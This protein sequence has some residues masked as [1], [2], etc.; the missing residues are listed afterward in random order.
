MG[1][2]DLTPW[3]APSQC[4]VAIAEQ[5]TWEVLEPKGCPVPRKV[6]QL[7]EPPMKVFALG[8][9]LLLV[10]LGLEPR[11]SCTLTK[12]CTP[13][14]GFTLESNSCKSARSH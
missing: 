11:A 8:L 6:A 4:T 7:G 5:L 13:V 2:A 10:V 1:T 9:Y 14:L 12:C 3:E